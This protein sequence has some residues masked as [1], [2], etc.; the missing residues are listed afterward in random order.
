MMTSRYQR[1]NLFREPTTVT[2]WDQKKMGSASFYPNSWQGG[3]QEKRARQQ[4]PWVR[5]ER[6][7]P[8]LAHMGL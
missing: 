4:P 7:A 3:K 6:L 5:P 2:K 1:E 8:I